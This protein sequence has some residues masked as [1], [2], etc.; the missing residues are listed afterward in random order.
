VR[1]LHDRVED[2]LCER[3]DLLAPLQV[4]SLPRDEISLVAK[5]FPTTLAETAIALNARIKRVSAGL[6]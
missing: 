3:G 5:P 6:R 4:R 2:A 1:S